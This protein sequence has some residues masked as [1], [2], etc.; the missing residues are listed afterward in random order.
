MADGAHTRNY[1]G[2]FPG[3]LGKNSCRPNLEMI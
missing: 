1:E 3:F 2:G